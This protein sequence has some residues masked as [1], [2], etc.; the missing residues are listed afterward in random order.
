M[1]NEPQPGSMWRC[2]L[3][4]SLYS[5]QV[6]NHPDLVSIDRNDELI[7]MSPVVDM[8]RP[9]FFRTYK[10]LVVVLGR[11]MKWLTWQENSDFD[12]LGFEHWFERLSER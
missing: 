3:Q 7:V 8:H 1:K 6:D 11:T 9:G 10:L 2:K 12:N 5:V 4:L